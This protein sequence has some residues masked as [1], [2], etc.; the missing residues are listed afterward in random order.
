MNGGEEPRFGTL[1]EIVQKRHRSVE[2]FATYILCFIAYIYYISKCAFQIPSYEWK[3]GLEQIYVW[4][5]RLRPLATK[6]AYGEPLI[7]MAKWTWSRKY[8]QAINLLFVYPPTKPK[9]AA[10]GALSPTML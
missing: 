9:I 5:R 10:A 3:S 1:W 4:L 2:T 8:R 7:L 6:S